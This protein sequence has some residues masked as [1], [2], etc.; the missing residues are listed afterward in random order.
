[1]QQAGGDAAGKT[2]TLPG[3]HG[4]AGP[5]GIDGGD[6]GMVT[7]GQPNRAAVLFRK[8]IEVS[9][10]KKQRELGY[11]EQLKQ[12]IG[13]QS[14]VESETFDLAS[15]TDLASGYTSLAASLIS[16]GEYDEAAKQFTNAL[17]VY[18]ESKEYPSAAKDEAY[19]FV[20]K[21]WAEALASRR[22]CAQAK[23]H[24][25][26]A[27]NLFPQV[28]KNVQDTDFASIQYGI[29][30]SIQ[31]LAAPNNASPPSFSK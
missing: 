10:G 23:D 3:Q 24:F 15:V 19:A 14:P 20:H 21:F 17:N 30:W 2:L 28:R 6:V 31:C 7:G 12:L 8:A 22:E 29:T 1:M 18:K 9:Q 4:Q 13:F 5:Q 27:L 26:S 16:A 11:W 25:Y